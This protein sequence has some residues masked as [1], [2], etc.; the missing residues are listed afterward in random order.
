M[1]L[2]G[3]HTKAIA[4]IFVLAAGFVPVAVC[5][6]VG[7]QHITASAATRQ[8]EHLSH[9]ADV[10][11]K[12][13][14]DYRAKLLADA[15]LLSFFAR[16]HIRETAAAP[17]LA[18]ATQPVPVA[19]APKPASPAATPP[20]PPSSSPPQGD[21]QAGTLR[22]DIRHL[23]SS[24]LQ[25]QL[26]NVALLAGDERLGSKFAGIDWIFRESKRQTGGSRWQRYAKTFAP[27]LDTFRKEK[28]YDDLYLISTQGDIV[29]TSG[30][31]PELGANIMDPGLKGS[32]L[33]NL[34]PHA[35]KQPALEDGSPYGY[36]DKHPAVFAGAPIRN[37]GRLVGIIALRLNVQE[38]FASRIEKQADST[39][40]AIAVIGADGGLRF[41]N[42]AW[43]Q[44]PASLQTLQAL[45]KK[46][47]DTSRGMLIPEGSQYQVAWDR[48]KVGQSEWTL[49]VIFP[50][51]PKPDPIAPVVV[52]E[53]PAPTI[54]PAA[55]AH[56]TPPLDRAAAD[57]GEI[58][59]MF[60][61]NYLEI[62]G[63]YDLFLIHP[64][65]VV[66]H[67]AMG[68]SDYGTHLMHGPYADTNLGILFRRVLETK[69]PALSDIAPY[70]PSR[71]EPAAFVAAPVVVDGKVAMVVALQHPLEKI[72][73]MLNPGSLMGSGGDIVLVGPDFRMRSDS[74][75]TPQTHSITASFRGT[76]SE[77]G[78]NT[79]AVQQ[80]LAGQRGLVTTPLPHGGV[81]VTAHIPVTMGDMTW[82]LLASGETPPPFSDFM[83]AGQKFWALVA[84]C[85]A[86][87]VLFAVLTTR[88]G[89]DPWRQLEMMANQL[90]KGH[91][92]VLQDKDWIPWSKPMEPLRLVMER[93]FLQGERLHTHAT[94]LMDLFHQFE[95]HIKTLLQTQGKI[96]AIETQ[97]SPEAL[98]EAL[99]RWQQLPAATPVPS[100]LAQEWGTIIQ[101]LT[102]Q[103]NLVRET[104][105]Q[106][107]L[108][109]INA[110]SLAARPSTKK[111]TLIG[112]FQKIRDLSES[113]IHLA[114]EGHEM[115]LSWRDKPPPPTQKV[116]LDEIL[117]A[118]LGRVREMLMLHIRLL[119]NHKNMEQ[120]DWNAVQ[121][122][123]EE[124]VRQ[125]QKLQRIA[126]SFPQRDK[127]NCSAPP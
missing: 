59:K 93:F 73:N 1:R 30:R 53:P 112:S 40:G 36:G 72:S 75:L 83:H 120:R 122:L 85:I 39:L 27:K 74:F 68:Q 15:Q 64:D 70:P 79:P 119:E 17:S 50:V 38:H 100:T 31:G 110:T 28:K 62:T 56:V 14:Q 2:S 65:G 54:L 87:V 118:L 127:D 97:D 102:E 116:S 32:G 113:V 109:S 8:G 19:I 34:F 11:K 77:N 114:N 44:L 117:T 125:G 42:H 48:F 60:G 41:H 105:Y 95:S 22:D 26:D 10:K 35:L 89:R 123:V 18:E 4:I 5:F 7:V 67:T 29:Y 51:I 58:E 108:Q 6:W 121:T 57:R 16:R 91:T 106:I 96:T 76:V 69:E 115:S 99:V 103:M 12:L 20:P 82:A 24:F 111:I 80:A 107:N 78:M 23:T 45:P 92:E 84:G 98:L 63:Y 104:A 124:M 101:K 47:T 66:F 81:H 37:N 33:F 90:A 61:K 46:V 88:L 49:L 43:A 71:N 21:E 94:K 3:F 25:Q 55:T 126:D 13:L 9:S 52:P 86:W